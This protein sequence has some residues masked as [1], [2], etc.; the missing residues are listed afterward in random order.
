MPDV[1]VCTL[2]RS[3]PLRCTHLFGRPYFALW[4]RKE[5]VHAL[6]HMQNTQHVQKIARAKVLL[7]VKKKLIFWGSIEIVTYSWLK[8]RVFIFPSPWPWP[9]VPILYSGP[10]PQICIYQPP[11]LICIFQPRAL[12]F[13]L[14]ALANRVGIIRVKGCI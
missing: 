14:L 4:K 1:V 13:Y 8:Y 6:A 10:S 9:Q 2:R 11:L 12:N 3:K 5:H 7:Q